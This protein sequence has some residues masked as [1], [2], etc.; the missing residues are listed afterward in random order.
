MYVCLKIIL[1]VQRLDEL[2]T[3]NGR[4]I[5]ILATL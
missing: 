3:F 1:K 4:V 5:H 2:R